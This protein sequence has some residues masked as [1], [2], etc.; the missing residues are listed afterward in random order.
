MYESYISWESKAPKFR[1][2]AVHDLFARRSLSLAE[3]CV[4]A[5]GIPE[6]WVRMDPAAALASIASYTATI[7]SLFLF[8]GCKATLFIAL[9]ALC[10][11]TILVPAEHVLSA[12]MRLRCTLATCSCICQEH[13]GHQRLMNHVQGIT[14][15][16]KSNSM[17]RQDQRGTSAFCS[18]A[19]LNGWQGIA[20]FPPCSCSS[21]KQNVLP[22]LSPGCA[23]QTWCSESGPAKRADHMSLLA[24]ALYT[25]VSKL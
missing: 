10:L 11:P 9:E 1:C 8:M 19:R 2:R 3:S 24:R 18:I 22:T 7:S 4:S 12:L 17:D 20:L 5:G 6:T 13:Q 25:P 15:A 21:S 14:Q 16:V 23:V